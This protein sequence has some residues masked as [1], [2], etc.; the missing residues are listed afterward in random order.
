MPNYLTLFQQQSFF[1]TY[2]NQWFLFDILMGVLLDL[3]TRLYNKIVFRD[4]Q[5]VR[6]N[7]EQRQV[8][9]DIN[10]DL[11]SGYWIL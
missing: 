5:I 2:G 9:P 7:H 6:E 10:G 1:R 4:H 8:T 3:L 11:V